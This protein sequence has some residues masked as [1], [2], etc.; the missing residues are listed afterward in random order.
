MPLHYQ[1]E[2]ARGYLIAK[3][4]GEW[5]LDAV[6]GLIDA[7]AEDFRTHNCDRALVDCLDVEIEGHVLDFERYVTGRHIAERLRNV[8]LAT[9]FPEEQITK[10]AESV[11]V[12]AGAALLVTSDHDEALHWLLEGAAD[13]PSLPDENT[14]D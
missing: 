7:L 5:E 14:V 8:R 4:T 6:A 9:L 10:F 13:Q 11:A 12:K 3:V 2:Q 1:I